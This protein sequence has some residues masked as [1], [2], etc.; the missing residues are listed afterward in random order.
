MGF[1]GGGGGALP[2]H[3]HTNIPLTGGPLDFANTTIAS[4]TAN[5]MTYSDGAALQELT[6]G[7]DAQV[8]GVSG[9][10]PSWITNTSN[11]LVK[12]SKT[13]SDIATLE[14]DIYTL[15]E[16]SALVNV[17]ADITT[18][19]DVSTAVTIGD[20]GDANG[21]AEATDWTA[22]TGLSDSTRGAYVTSFKTMR[23]TSGTTAIKAYGFSTAGGS[24]FDQPLTNTTNGFSCCIG[25]QELAQQFNTGHVLVGESISHA[26]FFLNNDATSP[27]GDIRCFIRQS[28]GT[29]IQESSTVL[30]AT[31]LTA[32]QAEYSFAFPDV[33]LS[34]GDMI[35]IAAT[36]VT[37]M[38]NIHNQ[39]TEM[40]N[41]KLYETASTG[42]A[43]SQ[44]VTKE[45]KMTVTYGSAGDTQ[46]AV[47]FY[48]QVVD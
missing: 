6:I 29:L 48:L 15:P 8:L 13:F 40:T 7:A 25:R 23:S 28:D 35:T 17:W 37:L 44:M 45:L 21:F 16:D 12:V 10:T 2:N 14:M 39:T 3:Q 5:S 34:A 19:F 33:V 46:G 47:D 42:S 9:G 24:T 11:P 36:N 1:G 32:S 26:S 31:T 20:A 43:Y 38:C 4:L 18:A 30:D 41:G 22:G 27:T